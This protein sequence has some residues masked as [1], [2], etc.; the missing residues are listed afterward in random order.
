MSPQQS[1]NL[2]AGVEPGL[3]GL[4]HSNRNFRNAD[5]WGKN[6]FNS[7]FPA[8]LT[9][10]M[11]AQ[12]INPVYLKLGNDLK[13][14]HSQISVAELYGADPAAG[15]I[16]YAFESGYAPYQPL[17]SGVFPRTDLVT[18]DRTTGTCLRGLEVKLTALPD[19]TTCNLSEDRY[20]CELV[21]RP[22]T[23]VYLACSLAMHYR[24]DLPSL[25]ALIG[26]DFKEIMKWD[27]GVSITS[28]VAKMVQ[29]IDRIASAVI[30]KQ[31]PVLIQPVWKTKGKS[32]QLADHCLDVFVWSDLAFTQ[33]FLNVARKELNPLKAPTRQVR[34][35]VWLFKMLFDFSLDGK[36]DHA[37]VID[38]LTYDTKNDKA[39]AVSGQVTNPYMRGAELTRPRITKDQIKEIIL[40][41]GQQLLSPER[42]FDAIIFNSPELF[43]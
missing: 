1:L 26:E 25:R 22:D 32:P 16:F 30:D 12:G 36:I 17:I 7:S 5:S 10:Y 39:F 37:S 11:G 38:G 3:F 20:G 28:S 9:A 2:S 29:A 42:R 19:N 13:T 21:V 27:D 24:Q 4:K 40:G 31:E 15:N 6:Q 23:I 14:Y 43:K 8:A 34:T 35:V 41:N 33:L 18:M